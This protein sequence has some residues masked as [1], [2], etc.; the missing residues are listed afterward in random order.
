MQ[1]L[2]RREF[3]E[4]NHINMNAIDLHNVFMLLTVTVQ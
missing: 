4:I 3:D 1:I 2:K